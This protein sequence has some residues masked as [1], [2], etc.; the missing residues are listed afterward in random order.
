M[1]RMTINLNGLIDEVGDLDA[2]P[3]LLKMYLRDVEK[4]PIDIDPKNPGSSEL[5]SAF[6]MVNCQYNVTEQDFSV[7][8]E[9]E[10]IRL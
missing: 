10:P 8:I 5:T 1:T 4:L 9:Y 6:A 3:Y 7:D 2:I